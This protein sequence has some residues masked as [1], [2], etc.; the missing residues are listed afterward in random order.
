M[1]E[2]LDPVLLDRVMNAVRVESR[3][4]MVVRVSRRIKN[5]ETD[6]HTFEYQAG[7]DVGELQKAVTAVARRWGNFAVGVAYIVERV[8]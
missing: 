7:A 3:G 4:P 2:D 6:S 8:Q 5:K 1:S